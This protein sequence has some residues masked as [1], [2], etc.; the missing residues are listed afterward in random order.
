MTPR[1]IEVRQH[2]PEAPTT[3]ELLKDVVAQTTSL[4]ALEVQ[5]ARE[6]LNAELQEMRRAAIAA[7]IAAGGAV[8]GVCMLAVALVLALGG[9]VV[10]ALGVAGGFLV[11]G[12]IAGL[13]GW[14]M[15]PKKPLERTRQRL[16][17]DIAQLRERLA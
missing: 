17:G 6:E 9:T 14:S 10:A 3:A 15:M 13:I 5:L 7:G 8:I 11:L 1:R 2:E 12:M 4:V 16:E